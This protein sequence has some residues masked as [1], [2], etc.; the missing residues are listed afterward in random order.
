MDDISLT[1][2]EQTFSFKGELMRKT[3]HISSSIIPIGY[4]F[5][6]RNLLL[7]I[8]LPIILAML[9]VEFLKYKSSFVYDLYLKI[10]KVML[11][12]H[13]FDL[14]RV[15][16]NGA[17][18]LLLGDIVCIMVFPKFIAITGMLL[19]SLSDSFSAIIGKA[20]GKKQYAPNRSIIGSLTFFIVGILIVFLT[21][22]YYYSPHEYAMA[23]G[24]VFF[25]TLI[26]ALNLPMDDNFAIP[27]IS[28]VLLYVLYILFYPGIFAT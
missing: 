21:P 13:E 24:A 18:W 6:E 10:F 2:Q 26:D 28:S 16:F 3:L 1:D 15:R 20:F 17:T 5:L 7:E 19:L 11:R 27:I 12:E 23:A 4:Y 14:K 25:T 8:L 9:L 22:K